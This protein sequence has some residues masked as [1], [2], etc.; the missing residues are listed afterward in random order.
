MILVLTSREVPALKNVLTRVINGE[1]AVDAET[2]KVLKNL[3]TT[4]FT[5]DEE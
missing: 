1:M 2:E 3:V 5:E 4:D